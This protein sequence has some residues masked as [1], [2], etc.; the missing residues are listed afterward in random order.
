MPLRRTLLSKLRAV[1][2]FGRHAKI[3]IWKEFDQR[4]S[5]LRKAVW[6]FIFDILGFEQ[7]GILAALLLL[8]TLCHGHFY[9]GGRL[10]PWEN[11]KLRPYIGIERVFCGLNAEVL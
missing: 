2:G 6:L 4:R 1:G 5:E 8:G 11:G 10:R 9:L 7:F 3:G